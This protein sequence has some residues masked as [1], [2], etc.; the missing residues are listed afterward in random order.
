MATAPIEKLRRLNRRRSTIGCSSVSSQTRNTTKP[1]AA[2]TAIATIW[3]DSNQSSSL[4]LSNI[5][6]SAPTQITSRARP[7]VSIGIFNAALSRL[8]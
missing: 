7:T 8:R 4:P 2:T 3:L 5:I 6:C 1:T